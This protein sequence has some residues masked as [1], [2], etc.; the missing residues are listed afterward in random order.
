M[1]F[2]A[3][4]KEIK[5]QTKNK[6]K[7]KSTMKYRT[8]GYLQRALVY[9]FILY[10]FSGYLNSVNTAELHFYPVSNIFFLVY[11]QSGWYGIIWLPET[12]PYPVLPRRIQWPGYFFITWISIEQDEDGETAAAGDSSVFLLMPKTLSSFKPIV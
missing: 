10:N 4:V 2:V 11:M 3:K 12:Q 5:N 8:S 6:E 1:M 9:V 7:R